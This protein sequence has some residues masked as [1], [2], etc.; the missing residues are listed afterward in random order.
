MYLPETYTR[1]IRPANEA[2]KLQ[3]NG[4]KLFVD[5]PLYLMTVKLD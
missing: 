4:D 3:E 1:N 2:H 5:Q